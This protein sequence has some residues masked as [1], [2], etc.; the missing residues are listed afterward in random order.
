[1]Y[2]RSRGAASVVLI[3]VTTDNG[4]EGTART[5]LA[6][7]FYTVV[8]R[9]AVAAARREWHER[10]LEYLEHVADLTTT[11]ELLTFWAR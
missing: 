10:S 8:V 11:A 2:L 6:R 1:M 5:A 9:D 3:G 4:I 7:G